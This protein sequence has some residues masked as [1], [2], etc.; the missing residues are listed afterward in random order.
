MH[1]KKIKAMKFS[2]HPAV[3]NKRISIRYSVHIKKNRVKISHHVQFSV[4]KISFTYI[5]YYMD[6]FFSQ[7][8]GDCSDWLTGQLIG[9]NPKQKD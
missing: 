1:I 5:S 7:Y 8:N 4:I 3:C 9:P 2:P 6:C